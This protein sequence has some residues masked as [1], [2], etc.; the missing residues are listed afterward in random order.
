MRG[1]VSRTLRSTPGLA[2]ESGEL[3]VSGTYARYIP[4]SHYCLGSFEEAG[5]RSTDVR[6]ARAQNM[7]DG[8]CYLSEPTFFESSEFDSSRP[9]ILIR[10]REA[11]GILE[12]DVHFCVA[13]CLDI[14][15]T[16]VFAA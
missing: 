12:R 7:G 8:G 4:R 15:I 10:P 9:L 13:G 6:S 14:G 2:E 1:L 11:G 16:F 3:R 5:T